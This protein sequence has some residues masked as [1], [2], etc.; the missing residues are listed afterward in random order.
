MCLHR[1][2]NILAMKTISNSKRRFPKPI[3]FAMYLVL[4]ATF[5][6]LNWMSTYANDS[7]MEERSLETRLAEALIPEADPEPEL[8]P[9]LLKLSDHS[10]TAKSE[11]E[12]KLEDRLAEALKP[13]A[14]PEP[15]VEGWLLTLS[16]DIL[17]K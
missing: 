10:E 3:K 12:I 1:N 14:D 9:W 7:E 16:E 17:G 11:E 2:F 13:A 15:K 6:F 4:V 8:E 5:G